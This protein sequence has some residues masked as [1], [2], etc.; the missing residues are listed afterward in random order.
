MYAYYQ[1][2]DPVKAQIVSKY[3]KLVPI[4]V[5]DMTGHISGMAGKV[6][7]GCDLER[8]VNIPLNQCEF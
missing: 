6:H 5:Q 3:D 4:F 2:C 7:L 8:F 1:N